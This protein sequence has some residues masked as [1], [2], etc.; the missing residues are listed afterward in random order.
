M[1]IFAY[2]SSGM[3]FVS[4][5]DPDLNGSSMVFLLDPNICQTPNGFISE[6]LLSASVQ[7]RF[8]VPQIHVLSKSDL[9]EEEEIEKI[10]DWSTDFLKLENDVN[11]QSEGMYREMSV[12]FCRSIDELGETHEIIPLSSLKG[13]GME[14]LYAELS[15]VLMGGS[16]FFPT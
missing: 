2:R 3:V 8:F 14:K 9:I 1:E 12:K 15:R 10:I 11:L 16:D 6:I 13:E 4:T 5:M 7:Y